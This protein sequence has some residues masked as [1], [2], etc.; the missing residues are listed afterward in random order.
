MD[1]LL[2]NL[3]LALGVVVALWSLAWCAV[4]V[5][6]VSYA[7]GGS[8]HFSYENA[9]PYAPFSGAPKR[10][11]SHAAWGFVKGLMPYAAILVL[12]YLTAGEEDGAG[13]ELI[14]GVVLL[15]LAASAVM[16]LR[17]A[18]L[19]AYAASSRGIEGQVRYAH[20]HSL[21]SAAGHVLGFVLLWV[22]LYVLDGR[23]FFL[24]GALGCGALLGQTLWGA[25]KAARRARQAR[26]ES[27]PPAAQV[28]QAEDIGR[29]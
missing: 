11:V 4:I 24:G 14:L 22:S 8:R 16:N 23:P 12:F 5:Q 1:A 13:V 18:V 3:W 17:G 10:I 19:M 25:A 27:R 26:G 28:N 2:G 15:T 20:W 6:G 7:R 21:R 9:T 29:Q